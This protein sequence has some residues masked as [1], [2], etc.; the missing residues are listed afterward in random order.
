MTVRVACRSRLATT[1]DGVLEHRKVD[2][3]LIPIC[4]IACQS[5]HGDVS[6]E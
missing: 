3:L 1:M 4:L 2:T 5:L 6:G